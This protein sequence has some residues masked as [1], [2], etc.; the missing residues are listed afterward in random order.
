M[1]LPTGGENTPIQSSFDGWATPDQLTV[2]QSPDFSREVGLTDNET[3]ESSTENSM[4][5]AVGACRY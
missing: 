2:T 3:L 4:N 1:E 5:G